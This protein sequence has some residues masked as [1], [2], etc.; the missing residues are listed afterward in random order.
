MT[1]C[2]PGGDGDDV[3]PT[4]PAGVT[5]QAGSATSVHVMW[6]GSTDDT[7]VA[8]YEV[9]R[10][11][12][13]AVDVPGDRHMVD[14]DGLTPSTTY[15]FSVRAR[16]AAGNLSPAAAE[17]SVTTPAA[18]PDD[19]TPP[20][21]PEE[22]RGRAEGARAASLRWKAAKDDHGVSSYEVHQGGTAIHSVPGDATETL[23]TGLRPGVRYSFTVVARDAAGNASPASRTVELTTDPAP[24]GGPGTAPG[25]FRATVRTTG[26]GTH[27]DLSWVP[28]AT[29]GRI[30]QYEIHLDGKLATTLNWSTGTS[31]GRIE[32]D[33]YLGRER[34]VTHT[35]RLR[36]RLPDGTWGAFSE[37][38]T[39]TTDGAAGG[40]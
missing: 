36:A 5:A 32:Y 39:V 29:G 1:G 37:R 10:S 31:G 22:A 20:T 18:A 7:G 27:L 13:K 24:G 16:D 30:T 2:L 6:N 15:T 23:V 33:L 21:R 3:P 26:D 9:L 12:E 28:P 25:D 11:G 38:R 40:G 17:V 19:D 4:T 14:V 8:G 35:V 34:D